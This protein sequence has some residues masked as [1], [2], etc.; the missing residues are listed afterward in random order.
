MNN[1][2]TFYCDPA[3]VPY[4]EKNSNQN[5][6][7]CIDED[8]RSML[9]QFAESSF[10]ANLVS[11]KK[12]SQKATFCNKILQPVKTGHVAR[13]VWSWKVI[14]ERSTTLPFIQL[15]LQQAAK[16]VALFCYNVVLVSQAKGLANFTINC[17]LYVYKHLKKLLK[18]VTSHTRKCSLRFAVFEQIAIYT[19]PMPWICSTSWKQEILSTSQRAVQKFLNPFDL[20]C[21]KI[22]F[23]RLTS[24]VQIYIFVS[25]SSIQKF[26]SSVHCDIQHTRNVIKCSTE[27]QSLQWT[28]YFFKCE[29]CQFG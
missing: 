7:P 3:K 17:I 19:S 4:R 16:Q 24:A 6:L 27:V 2:E 14:V 10:W 26:S 28:S 21:S 22:F 12:K 18:Y 9:L 25:H 29:I 5:R 1:P 20:I 15:V 8:L 11:I 23:T 13:Q